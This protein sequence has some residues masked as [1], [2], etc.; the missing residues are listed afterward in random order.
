MPH[1]PSFQPDRRLF[2]FESR[3]FESTVGTV[4][5]LDEGEGPPI[6]F[7][8]GNPTW[9]FLYRGVIIR[10]RKRFRCIA[11]DYP[12]FGLSAHPDDYGYTPAEH[13]DVVRA[14]VRH[15]DL[16]D[17]T[18]MGHDW[19][20]PIGLRVALDEMVRLR[21]L[22]MGNT[23]YWP[24]DAWHLKAFAYVMSS[25]PMQTQVL[26]RN[27]FVER[28]IPFG[29]KYPL[30]EEVLDHYREPL[31]TPRSRIGVAELPRQL[32]EASLWLGDLAD[33][34]RDRLSNVP[35]LLTWGIEDLAYPRS[36]MERFREDFRLTSIHRVDAKHFIQ[37]DAP[38]E[39]AEAI[40]A[41]LSRPG[42]RP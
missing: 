18:I 7:L 12:G 6:L 27:F 9:S 33:E 15:L 38:G 39:V 10:L 1:I 20:G 28:V 36:F 29:V 23:W 34:V 14:L 3:W 17:L 35:M 31:A 24:V 8:H 11:V 4:H 32:L 19:G 30:A 13:A 2:P 22:V 25:A 16:K 5:Y 42:S 21:A 26:K 37:E 41:F 40:E